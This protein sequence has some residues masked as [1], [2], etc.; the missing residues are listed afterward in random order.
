MNES[1]HYILQ[2][3]PRVEYINHNS[4]LE[5]I[6]N[7]G[8]KAKYFKPDGRY[9]TQEGLKKASDKWIKYLNKI[10]IETPPREMNT[11]D[12]AVDHTV[13]PAQA[14]D[15]VALFVLGDSEFM[16]DILDAVELKN[17]LKIPVYPILIPAM[18]VESLGTLTT[19]VLQPSQKAL[20]LLQTLQCDVFK[21]ASR[22]ECSAENKHEMTKELA[23]G[24]CD[25][26][27]KLLSKCP[28]LEIIISDRLPGSC[29][30]LW[31]YENE[32]SMF[33]SFYLVFNF[34]VTNP[35]CVHLE[36]SLT[37]FTNLH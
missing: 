3:H 21:I 19:Q 26:I 15:D 30:I 18:N 7:E 33:F 13:H 31:R 4:W 27:D 10:F 12:E 34:K 11:V 24:F 36:W 6:D 35:R 20:A 8:A 14:E 2:N 37:F 17:M 1:I 5:D 23:L 16:R 25:F 32:V 22:S 28:Q 29:V 9:L